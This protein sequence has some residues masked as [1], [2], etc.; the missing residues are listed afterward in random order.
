MLTRMEVC[1]RRR[2]EI[3]GFKVLLLAFLCL[4]FPSVLLHQAG[5]FVVLTLVYSETHQ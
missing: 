4:A 2:W 1:V 3:Y 5:L